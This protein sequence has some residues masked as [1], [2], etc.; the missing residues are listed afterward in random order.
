MLYSQIP[1]KMRDRIAVELGINLG[2]FSLNVK[3][4][5]N[6]EKTP[7]QT[8]IEKLRLVVN[9][10]EKNMEVGTVDQPKTYFKGSLPMRWGLYRAQH[11]G[12]ADKG[13]VYFGG[14]TA[15]TILGLGAHYIT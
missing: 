14:E 2:M 9:Y 15:E 12:Q 4:K 10:I 5:E 6:E 1:K 7:L 8:R 3:G 11:L 13:I